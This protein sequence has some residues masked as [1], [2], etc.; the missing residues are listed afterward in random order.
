LVTALDGRVGVKSAGVS[1]QGCVFFF[2]LPG[3]KG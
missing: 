1:G 2:T 3:G